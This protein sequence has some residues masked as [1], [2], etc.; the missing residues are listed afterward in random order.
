MEKFFKPRSVAIIGASREVHKVGFVIMKNLI[1]AGYPGEI[2]PINPNAT[3]IL[4]RSCYPSVLKVPGPIDLAVIAVPAK[5][6]LKVI[7]ECG[8][9]NIRHIVM[10]TAGFSEIGDKAGEEA[11]IKK[12]KKY[13]MR[14]I[15]P[16]CLGVL[17][18][19]NKFDTL[20]LTRYLHCT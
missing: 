12:V 10:I 6:V 1:L 9:K 4:K 16:N 8:K 14:L 7:D 20:F 13:K 15:G 17:D 11:L 18:M 2:Y 19:N 3:N 5:G